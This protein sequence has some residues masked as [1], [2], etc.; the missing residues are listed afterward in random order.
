MNNL[1]NDIKRIK[2]IAE[3]GL[4]YAKDNYDRERYHELNDISLSMMSRLTNTP[5]SILTNF[6]V[7]TSDYP[8]PKVDIRAFVV[9]EKDEILLARES[10][11]GCW[12][13]PGGWA[14]IG[15]T[16][17]EVAVKEVFEE[18]GLHVETQHLMAIF[19]KKCHPH[20]PQL[21]YVYKIVLFCTLKNFP[22]AFNKGF[23]IL[24]VGYFN[25]HALPSLST[26]R[27]LENQIF[28]LFNQWKNKVSTPYCD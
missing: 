12:S 18:T 11:D 27:I 19:D 2:S 28:L 3:I 15:L 16:P 13:L 17:R 14:D 21:P 23:D 22:Q 10:A 25:I 4:L 9:N 26:H 5:L 7:E 8:T 1:L 6:Q 20:P 24:D